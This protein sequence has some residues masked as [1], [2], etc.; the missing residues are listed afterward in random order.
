VPTTGKRV[1]LGIAMIAILTIAVLHI[2][3]R[4]TP[5]ATGIR[6]TSDRA[7]AA[8]SRAPANERGIGRV[9]RFRVSRRRPFPGLDER[10]RTDALDTYA[11]E[12]RDES[13]APYMEMAFGR[14]YTATELS[15]YGLTDLRIVELSCRRVTCRVVYEY[16]SSVEDLLAADG[17]PR[18]TSPLTLIAEQEGPPAPLNLGW[19]RETFARDGKELVR[20]V[21]VFGFDEESYDPEH[22]DEWVD[23][24]LTRS[25]D[26][27]RRMPRTWRQ[28]DR[29]PDELFRGPD[30]G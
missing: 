12:P 1:L 5:V 16:P 20:M 7:E 28:D 17:L 19:S 30:A 15:R 10:L 3:R 8:A 27:F 2:R 24:Q 9:P 11:R 23:S 26:A 14:R 21:A 29:E 6:E 18:S 22:Y 25:Q 4:S 13:W